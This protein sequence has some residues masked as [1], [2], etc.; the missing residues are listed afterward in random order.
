MFIAKSLL[1]RELSKFQDRTNNIPKL[2][3]QAE[4]TM[5]IGVFGTKN[6]ANSASNKENQLVS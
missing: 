2:R 1:V 6:Y 5:T 3:K 4:S